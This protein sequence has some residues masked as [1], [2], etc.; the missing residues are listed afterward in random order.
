MVVSHV[1]VSF[2]A[3]VMMEVMGFVMVVHWWFLLVV[4]SRLVSCNLAVWCDLAPLGIKA[5]HRPAQRNTNDIS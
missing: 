5:S 2:R 1:D 3:V 4:A